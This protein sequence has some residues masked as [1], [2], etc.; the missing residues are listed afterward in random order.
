MRESW[1]TRFGFL[2][3]TAGFSIGLGN[4]WR[5]PYLV[6][7]NGGG[8]FLAVYVLCAVLIGVPLFTAELSLGRRAQL[9]PIPGM[10]RLTGRAG[11]PWNL[12]GWLGVGAAFLIQSYYVMLIGWVVAYCVRIARGELTGLSPEAVHAAFDS[13]VA[14]PLP[15]LAYTVAVVV[16]LGAIVAR[17]IQKGIEAVARPAL[18]ALFAL[19]ALLAIRSLSLPGASRGLLFYLRPDFSALTGAAVLAALGQAFYSIGV[20][21]GAGFHFGS[22]LDPRRSDVPGSA[23]AVVAF[24]TLA[25]FLAG[26]VIF[27]ALFAVGLPP[28]A[29]PG[30][31][32]VS[33][34]T[35]FERMP[36]GQLFGVAF[37]FFLILAGV[38]SAMAT[39]EVLVASLCDLRGLGRRTAVWVAS[40]GVLVLS[41]PVILSQGPWSGFRFL[42]RDIFGLIDALSGTILLTVGGLLI[43]V[44][45]AVAWGFEAFRRDTNLGSGPV[46]VGAAWGPFVRVLIPVTVGLILLA[47]LGLV[48]PR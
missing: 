48:Q 23:A 26:L 43:A 38:T 30:L 33:M 25:A 41:V 47:G 5:F 9:S 37:F 44:Y 29:G 46:K 24:D 16:L 32:F 22:Y 1:R 31:L 4:V 2:T 39:L 11:S 36:G 40:G 10:R 7:M 42:D 12:I 14:S 19:L 20:G 3:A 15:V 34:P 6:G 28:D 27:P 17:G 18:P 45:T 35:L 8:A 21:M 13:F